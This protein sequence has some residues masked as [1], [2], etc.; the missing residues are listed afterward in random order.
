MDVTLSNVVAYNLG[1][2]T[3]KIALL[4]FT[5]SPGSNLLPPAS[6][7]PLVLQAVASYPPG[8]L[9]AQP[10]DAEGKE[11]T[12]R[13]KLCF[14]KARHFPGAYIYVRACAC[15]VLSLIDQL[16]LRALPP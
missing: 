14:L 1:N 13:R 2:T 11:L 7:F 15:A 6:F 8:F 9:K 3:I 16:W 5:V 4:A 10:F 12:K